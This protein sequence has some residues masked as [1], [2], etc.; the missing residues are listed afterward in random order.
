MAGFPA[1]FLDHEITSEMEVT[2]DKTIDKKLVG[3]RYH[4]AP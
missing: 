4:G 2:C 3:V 1:A